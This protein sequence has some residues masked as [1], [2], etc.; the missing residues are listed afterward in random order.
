[1]S[2][3]R[4][5]TQL[6]NAATSMQSAEEAF[7]PGDGLPDDNERG[8]YAQVL[9]LI[10]DETRRLER[11]FGI[12]ATLMPPR[13]AP[14]W[15]TRQEQAH[16]L[17]GEVLSIAMNFRPGTEQ[18][19]GVGASRRAVEHMREALREFQRAQMEVIAS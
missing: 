6:R 16:E 18:G 5:F 17:L 19:P 11:R 9:Y 2:H 7:E 12:N 15:Q 1:M 4:A 3:G 10:R 13:D 8:R 14:D